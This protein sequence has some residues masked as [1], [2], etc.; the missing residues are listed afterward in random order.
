MAPAQ[1]LLGP[2]AGC[3][4]FDALVRVKQEKADGVAYLLV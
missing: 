2:F 3:T 1:Y 4:Y